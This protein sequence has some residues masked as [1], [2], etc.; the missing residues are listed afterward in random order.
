MG[1]WVPKTYQRS[2]SFDV[3]AT[4][5]QV[6]LL[7]PGLAETSSSNQAEMSE[8]L[9]TVV[10]DADDYFTGQGSISFLDYP[11]AVSYYN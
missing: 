10:R 6:K 7:F 1:S 8:T 9:R 4:L 5:E 11:N 2:T 3:S